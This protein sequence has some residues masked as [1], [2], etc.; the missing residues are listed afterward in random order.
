MCLHASLFGEFV[1][2]RNHEDA[3]REIRQ[4]AQ[5]VIVEWTTGSHKADEPGDAFD[6]WKAQ[7]ASHWPSAAAK[8]STRPAWLTKKA[9]TV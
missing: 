4:W 6:F 2:R 7:Y 1:R 5:R 8:A 3:D 9:A